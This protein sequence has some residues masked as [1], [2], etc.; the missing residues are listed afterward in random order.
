MKNNLSHFGEEILRCS[1]SIS[2]L[3]PFNPKVSLCH[4]I[5]IANSDL[6]AFYMATDYKDIKRRNHQPFCF[7]KTPPERRF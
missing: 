5:T 4:R 1:F 3:F 6:T 2:F 7:L